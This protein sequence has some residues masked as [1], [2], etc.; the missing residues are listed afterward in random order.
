MG[1]P[2]PAADARAP[3]LAHSKR[4]RD[5]FGAPPGENPQLDGFLR[6]YFSSDLFT[7]VRAPA[8]RA[9]ASSPRPAPGNADVTPPPDASAAQVEYGDAVY[10]IWHNEQGYASASPEESPH[11]ASTAA[12]AGA[13]D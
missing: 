3:P 2:P 11:V 13:P 1:S 12:A 4:L 8:A 10:V 7:Q 9:R 5:L 6:A